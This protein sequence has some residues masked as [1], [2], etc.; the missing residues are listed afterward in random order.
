MIAH[1]SG[2]FLVNADTPQAQ[3]QPDI[4]ALADGGFVAV[5][6]SDD[7]APAVNEIRARIFDADATPRS[8]EFTVNT[9]AGPFF[10]EPS[11]A[12]L[13]GGRF[14]VVWTAQAGDLHGN[15]IRARV[16]EAD[17]TPLAADFL[18]NTLQTMDHSSYG[19]ENGNQANPD[20]LPLLDG[21]FLVAWTDPSLELE[22]EA[23]AIA[24]KA[25]KADGAAAGS[26]FQVN[27]TEP[28]DQMNPELAQLADG[29]IAAV[30]TDA[31]ETG[32][33]RV[34]L[35][36]RTTTFAAPGGAPAPD[37][38]VNT[39]TADDQRDAHVAA[40]AGGGYVVT[41]RD[42]SE[43]SGD[44]RLQLFASDGTPVGAERVVAPTPGI[45]SGAV[46]AGLPDGRFVVAWASS[47]ETL[48]QIFAADGTPEGDAETA[49][50]PS[51]GN[52]DMPSITVLS[53]GRFVVGWHDQSGAGGDPDGGIMARIFDPRSAPVR[54]DGT[55]GGDV[56]VGTV[57]GDDTL[58][59][60]AGDDR[61]SGSGG[62]DR[63]LGGAGDDTLAGGDG[64]DTLNGG[65]GDDLIRGGDSDADRRDVIL[66]GAGNDSIDAGHGN[67]E[68]FGQGGN[69]TIAGGFGA[70]TLQGQ[71]GND[72]I[73]GSAFGDIVFGN[74]GDDF[75][76][77]GFGHDLIN[78]GSGADK[79][80]H[81]GG[82]R[83]QML[84]HG[85][86]WVQDYSAAEGDVLVFGGSGNA[87]QFQ[88][89]F[90]HTANKTTGER[91]GDDGVQEAFVIYIP[92]GQI[93]WAL[94]DGA[95]Q[96]EINLQIGAEVFD[97]L[98]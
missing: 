5:W 22:V 1:W 38:V 59:G 45:Q 97:L 74:A 96:G 64:A 10:N 60:G 20:V 41:W 35:A 33:D 71:D 94:V 21:G 86:D 36:V 28:R 6:R 91:S 3:L 9:S 2:E 92:T 27:T 23:E 73:T 53:D 89:N 54:L 31:S 58:T 90:T 40:L 17:G 76:N 56:L 39:A 48:V 95:G 51:G 84:G 46:A 24:A 55:A 61:L 70:D 85:S 7:A 67:D 44:L 66:G 13:A 37:R 18:V 75:V 16:F 29:T 19:N 81:V 77:G 62:A 12:G 63:L 25:F 4:W 87:D 79:F 72:V 42:F 14:A 47:G 26:I 49:H 98:A 8:G 34:Q 52:Q 57:M 69:D 11:V 78:G 50:D 88:V 43:D 68:V 30:F 65:D 15:G 80:F 93:L 83:E 82:S 32:A